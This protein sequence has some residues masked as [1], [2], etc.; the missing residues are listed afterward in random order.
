MVLSVVFVASCCLLLISYLLLLI[1]VFA[2]V[3]FV[4]VFVFI[5]L[6]CYDVC[7]LLVG[8]LIAAVDGALLFSILHFLL[9]CHVFVLPTVVYCLF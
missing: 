5:V 2:H 9:L 3:Q 8:L 4:F 1:L 7:L 6:F